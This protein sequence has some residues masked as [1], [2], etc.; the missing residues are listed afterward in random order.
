MLF[1]GG[2]KQ[3][4]FAG[5][6]IFFGLAPDVLHEGFVPLAGAVPWF[7]L[8]VDTTSGGTHDLLQ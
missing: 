8:D 7:T 6:I 5:T 3:Y 4:L 1:N 2:E